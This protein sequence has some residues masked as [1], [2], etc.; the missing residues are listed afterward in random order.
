MASGKDV[1][2][3]GA[4]RPSLVWGVTYEAII[5]CIAT[6]GVI[7]LAANSIG[8]CLCMFLYTVLATLICLKDPVFQ[9][10]ILWFATKCRSIGWR[11]WGGYSLT[12]VSTR[13]EGKCQNSNATATKSR[14]W[15]NENSVAE[16][17]PYSVHLDEN[18]I[19]TTSIIFR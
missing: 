2:F 8:C 15:V 10:H 19:K 16:F 5:F 12:T 3:A 14:Q 13:K 11:Y 6:T 18:T 1:L 4:T 7:F 17:I 9:A